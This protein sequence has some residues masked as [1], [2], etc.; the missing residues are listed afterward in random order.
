MNTKYRNDTKWI[1]DVNATSA[2][3]LKHLLSKYVSKQ[4]EVKEIA[5]AL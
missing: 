2:F 1:I 5:I 4:I 3:L